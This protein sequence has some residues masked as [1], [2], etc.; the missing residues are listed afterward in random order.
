M[1]D[2]VRCDNE[3]NQLACYTS[4]VSQ[5]FNVASVALE[6]T[7]LEAYARNVFH[8]FSLSSLFI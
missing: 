1:A 6:A 5:A 2:I 4:L 7:Q 3:R 8:L